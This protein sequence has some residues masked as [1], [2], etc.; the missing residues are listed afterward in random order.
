MCYTGC[1]RRTLLYVGRTFFRLRKLH[2]CDPKL[3]GYGDYGARKMWV[4]VPFHVL[5]SQYLFDVVYYRSLRSSVLEP[6]SK[7]RLKEASVLCK[8]FGNLSTS[9]VKM[10]RVFIT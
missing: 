4:Y 5:C 9:F 6:I 2:Q 7:P 8:V 3:N 1:V 10:V